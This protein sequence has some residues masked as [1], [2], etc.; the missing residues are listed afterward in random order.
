M[1]AT[2]KVV[3]PNLRVTLIHSRD[4][5]LSLESLPIDFKERTLSVLRGTGV[6]V[7]LNDRVMNIHTEK[8]TDGSPLYT[9]VSKVGPKMVTSHAIEAISHRVP[10]TA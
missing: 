4:K 2:L 6:E 5:F 1:A 8:M 3:E 7:A 9:L 10:S